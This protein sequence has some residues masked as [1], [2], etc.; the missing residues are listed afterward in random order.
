MSNK[1]FSNQEMEILR[2]NPN[3]VKVTRRAV[4]FTDEFK[5]RALTEYNNG[6][7]ARKIFAEN[8]LSIDILGIIRIRGL[9]ER[10]SKEPAKQ[11][12]SGQISYAKQIQ[13]L[14]R[15]ITN[16]EQENEFLKKIRELG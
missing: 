6:K 14:E 4:C 10:I 9:I 5:A 1:L 16:L 15:R 13:K 3:V 8:G 2:A 7:S 12:P 11:K